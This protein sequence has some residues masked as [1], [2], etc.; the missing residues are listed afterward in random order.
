[1]PDS[2]ESH[3]TVTGL[4][5]ALIPISKPVRA[6]STLLSVIDKPAT[7]ARDDRRLQGYHD[8]STC[9]GDSHSMHEA[10]ILQREII[11]GV[12]LHIYRI[13]ERGPL[14]PGIDQPDYR[15]MDAAQRPL[16]AI[17]SCCNRCV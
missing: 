7:R 10:R 12:I 14:L 3:I 11:D 9:A 8:L 4:D 17:T 5:G 13:Y 15:L 1:M 16:P 6:A 2:L